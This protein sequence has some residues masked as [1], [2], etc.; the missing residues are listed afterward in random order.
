MSRIGK[1][2]ITIPENVDINY[3]DSEI[4]VKGKFGTLQT[5][6]PTVIKITES[7]NILTVGLSEQTRSVRA[8]HGLY[9]TL[10]N[11]MVIGV[12]EQFEIILE[13]KGVGYRAAVQNNEIILNLGYSHPVNIKIPNIISVEVVQ[14]TTINL[15]SCD[16]ELL[17]LFAANIRAWRQPEPYKGKGILYKG[18]QIIRKAG[19]S[20]K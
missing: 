11:N 4:T 8:L 9:R 20:A 5:Q 14:N 15:K 19:K 6:I 1:L 16:K 3:N 17:G 18:E 12:S 10:I 7:D 2:P 13:L